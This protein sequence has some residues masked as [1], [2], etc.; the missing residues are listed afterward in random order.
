MG[1]AYNDYVDLGTGWGTVFEIDQ[2][3][4]VDFWINTTSVNQNVLGTLD[5]DVSIGFRGFS[6]EIVDGGRVRAE[7]IHDI[8]IGDNIDIVTNESV[9]DGT[10]HHIAF[11]Y[12][13]SSTAAGST[14]AAG[15]QFYIDGE[16]ADQVIVTDNLVG[17]IV[18]PVDDFILGAR[19]NNYNENFEGS[20]D[21]VSIWNIVRSQCEIQQ[22]MNTELV[23]DE[24]GLVAYY[25]FN[26]GETGGNNSTETTLFEINNTANGTLNN[27]A[28][29]GDVSNWIASGV[30]LYGIGNFVDNF[31]PVPNQPDTDGEITIEITSLSAYSDE[32]MWELQDVNGAVIAS[33]GPYGASGAGTVIDNQTVTGNGPY[34]FYGSTIGLIGDNAFDY[35]ITCNGN[36]I[37]SGSVAPNSDVT[38]TDIQ[39]C[40]GGNGLDDILTGCPVTELTA[41]TAT[42]ACAGVVTGTYDVSLPITSSTVITWTYD[43]GNGN[44]ATQMQNVTIEQDVTAPIP[45][46]ATLDDLTGECSVMV[47][48]YPTATDDCS[49]V[50]TAS[51]TD[52]LEYTEQGTYT[53]TWTYDDGNGNTSIQNQTVVVADITLPTIT[54]VDNQIIDL[55]QGQS[56]YT[57]TGIEFDAT[58]DDNCGVMLLV[59]DYNS[60]FTL[61][62]EELI[63]GTYT[64][65]WVISDYAGNLA[66]CTFNIIV[67][68][69]VG[70][71][72]VTDFDVTVYPN[73]TTGIINI[74]NATGYQINLTDVSGRIL[75]SV[76]INADNSTIDLTEYAN[77]MYFIQFIDNDVVHTVKVIRK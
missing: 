67:N 1:E 53:I 13:G 33:G 55:L 65:T 32:V 38:V 36:E 52:P 49:G 43:D 28:L 66:Q 61:A 26:Q 59:N 63:P 44:T 75:Q 21:E 69:Y 54:C 35:Y 8:G 10:W 16:I 68:A 39:G 3:F 15:C 22:A 12:D 29:S 14:S 58:G 11:T 9:N 23:G 48:T 62:D 27:F 70:L 20:L 30:A 37:S 76:N 46:I 77:G 31:A 5:D 7:M 72:T 71:Q 73:P 2:T 6:I 18:P 19:S 42:D 41:P 60:D 40:E 25:N 64:V 17:S 51:T 56:T 45:D 74:K 47:S 24:V 50:V 4:S 57:V 34:T